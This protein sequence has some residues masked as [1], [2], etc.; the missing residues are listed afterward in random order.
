MHIIVHQNLCP[1][2]VIV[3]DILD[4]DHL[5]IM[6]TLTDS[7]RT[8]E[9]S[10]PVEKLTDWELFQRLISKLIPANILNHSDKEVNKAA[11]DFATYI[12]SAFMPSAR[13]IQ[14][15]TKYLL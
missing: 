12:V 14:I 4:S 3:T 6:F 1:S 15:N 8:S 9:A 5:P 11:R 10:D 13:K 7:V 2:E